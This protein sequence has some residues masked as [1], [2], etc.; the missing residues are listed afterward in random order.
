VK[1]VRYPILTI[2]EIVALPF[3]TNL[4]TT[5]WVV[6]LVLLYFGITR[7]LIYSVFP[8][9]RHYASPKMNKGSR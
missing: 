8:Q 3:I 5:F 9:E 2:A 1:I 6:G 7:V 4:A